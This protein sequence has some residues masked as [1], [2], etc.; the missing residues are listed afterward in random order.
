MCAVLAP[1]SLLT[2]TRSPAGVFAVA[3]AHNRA[4][5][6]EANIPFC[7]GFIHIIDTVLNPLPGTSPS[8]PPRPPPP[9]PPPAPPSPPLCPVT[10]YQ[11]IASI[12]ALAGFRALID[13]TNQTGTFQN[14]EFAGTIFAPLDCTFVSDL[15]SQAQVGAHTLCVPLV[16]SGTGAQRAVGHLSCRAVAHQERAVAARGH[17]HALH[18]R[19]GQGHALLPE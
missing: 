14:P 18:A 5:I 6:T 13:R 10:A 17:G 8:P 11:Q 9:P 19:G 1:R 15:R 7:N 2:V 12:P 16:E 3:G 4:I